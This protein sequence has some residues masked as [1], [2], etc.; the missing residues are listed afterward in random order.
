M[1]TQK[2]VFHSNHDALGVSELL[3]ARFGAFFLHYNAWDG[4]FEYSARVTKKGKVLTSRR[5]S[6]TSPANKFDGDGFNRQKNHLITRRRKYSRA[7]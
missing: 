3:N 5:K 1:Y 7:C 2:Q 6:E 4:E